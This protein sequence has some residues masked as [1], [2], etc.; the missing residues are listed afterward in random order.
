MWTAAR[1]TVARTARATVQPGG[2][3]FD[4]GLSRC[5]GACSDRRGLCSGTRLGREVSRGSRGL[6]NRRS[7]SP[8]ALI[9]LPRR[10]QRP[11]R[12]VQRGTTGTRGVLGAEARATDSRVLPEGSSRCHGVRNGPRVVQRA[13]SGV[14]SDFPGELRGRRAV[15]LPSGAHSGRCRAEG[16]A[17]SV[18]RRPRRGPNTV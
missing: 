1:M 15:V 12:V 17:M 3:R 10:M 16:T 5:S 18:G 11:S 2:V 7:G 4:R 13:F 9:S 8:R 14:R 6:G